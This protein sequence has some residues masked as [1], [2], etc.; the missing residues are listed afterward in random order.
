MK[1]KADSYDWKY[2][3][4][5]GSPRI[6]ITT[7]SDIEHLVE[8]DEKLWTVLS[9]PVKGLEFDAKTLEILDSDADGKIRVDEIK[10][11]AK[12]LTSVVKDSNKI[13][14]GEDCLALDAINAELAQGNTVV[15]RNFGT[16]MPVTR[17]AKVGRNPK[18]PAVD[19]AIPE[20]TV[21]KFK[22]GALLKKAAAKS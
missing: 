14:S 15:F 20:R 17:K 19:V 6:A 1:K 22:P 3:S 11:A 8:L 21:V 10:A 13:V 2:C 7:G 18:N 5:G 9:M 4:I 12:W 16:F